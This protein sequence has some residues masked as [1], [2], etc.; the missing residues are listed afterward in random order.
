[1]TVKWL[2]CFERTLQL[3]QEMGRKSAFWNLFR[4]PLSVCRI[5]VEAALLGH[6]LPN[7][8]PQFKELNSPEERCPIVLMISVC[9]YGNRLPTVRTNGIFTSIHMDFYLKTDEKPDSKRGFYVFLM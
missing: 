6:Q 4:Y 5:R 9:P 2:N 1:M 7:K 8:F 3:L